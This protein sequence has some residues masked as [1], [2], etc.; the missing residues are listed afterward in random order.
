MKTVGL[1]TYFNNI[2]RGAVLQAYSLYSELKMLESE[3]LGVRLPNI[4]TVAQECNMLK[5]RLMN[6]RRRGNITDYFRMKGAQGALFDFDGPRFRSDD[7]TR[8]I[9]YLNSKNYDWVC[10]GSDEVWK[11]H[12]SSVSPFSTLR[13][14]SRPFPNVYMADE[15]LS[16]RK[17]SYA[18]S[19]N[20][21]IYSK[22]SDVKLEF[23]E[24]ALRQFEMIG[25]RDRHTLEQLRFVGIKDNVHLVPDPT[26]LHDFNVYGDESVRR[27]LH[28]MMGNGG[29]RKVVSI[30]TASNELN[31]QLYEKFHG[32]GWVVVTMTANRHCDY[33]LRTIFSPLEWAVA[34]RLFDLVITK[35]FHELIFGLKAKVPAY[36]IDVG[37]VYVETE[38]KTKFLLEQLGLAER[39]RNLG[40]SSMEE[41]VNSIDPVGSMDMSRIAEGMENLALEGRRFIEKWRKML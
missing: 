27:K 13:E 34:F 15:R 21:A 22:L 2:G 8:S 32:M 1:L 14:T 12:G 28:S 6:V 35:S 38:S 40:T 4:C 39:Y 37:R 10:V 25:V 26:I 33:D 16:A 31:R 20:G 36:V 24:R 9:N 11:V 18:A 3:G 5:K 30:S 7:Y 29:K 17:I 19:A 41:T 23:I